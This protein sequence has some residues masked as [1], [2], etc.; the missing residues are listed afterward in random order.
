MLNVG[1]DTYT[2][3]IYKKRLWRAPVVRD[4]FQGIE[5][6]EQLKTNE[7]LQDAIHMCLLSKKNFKTVIIS[8]EINK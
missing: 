6:R 2:L 1:I 3:T 7:Q 5:I 8:I 4:T